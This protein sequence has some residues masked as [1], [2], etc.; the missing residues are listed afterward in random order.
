MRSRY[1]IVKNSNLYFITSTIVGWLPVFTEKIFCDII[2]NSLTYCR[3]KKGLRLFAYV[4]MDTHIHLLVSSEAASE[5]IR[6][7]KSYTAREIIRI[8]KENQRK[9][10]LKQFEFYKK[11]HKATSEYQVWQEGFH[12]QMV[13]QE[14]VL[15]QKVAYIHCNPVRRGLVEDAGH[16]VYS[17]AGNYLYGKGCIEI[18]QIEL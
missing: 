11:G 8:A 12:P 9:R 1:K 3:Q 7:F 10:L 4:V 14:D 13:A 5:I 18:D 6:D 2:V 16:W 15:R 17:S